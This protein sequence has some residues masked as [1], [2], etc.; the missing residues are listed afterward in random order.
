MDDAAKLLGDE[1][2]RNANNFVGHGN[3]MLTFP[4]DHGETMNGI[5]PRSPTFSLDLC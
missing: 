3:H 2:A 4:I 5:A 1:I